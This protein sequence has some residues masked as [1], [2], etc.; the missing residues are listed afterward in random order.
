[1][2]RKHPQLTNTEFEVL[3]QYI[4]DVADEMGLRDWLFYLMHGGIEDDDFAGRVDAAMRI[5][6][7]WGKKVANIQV[8]MDFRE[9][10]PVRQRQFVVHELVHCHYEIADVQLRELRGFIGQVAFDAWWIGMKHGIEQAVDACAEAIAPRM[11][12]IP[13]PD[14]EDKSKNRHSDLVGT[15]RVRAQPKGRRKARPRRSR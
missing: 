1:V 4:R 10:A 3:G 2:K 15:V 11:P 8:G 12:L 14:K 6:P 13:W 9:I 5:E 7:V